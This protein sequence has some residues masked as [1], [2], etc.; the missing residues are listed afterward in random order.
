M[1]NDC[2][3]FTM[4]FFQLI[5]QSARHIY[6]SALP[7][8]PESSIFSSMSLPG[9]FT[10][11]TTIGQGSTAKI[12]GACDDGTVRVYESVTG[13]LRLSLRPEF[14]VLEMTGVPDGSLLVCTYSG[15]PVITL[16]DIQTGR[17]ME[18][19]ILR[20]QA[21]HTTVSLE[22][23]YLACEGSETT[24][25]FWETA[26]RMQH[27]VPW[28]QFP[29]NTPCWLAPEDLI[30][31]VDQ[32]SI[33]IQNVILRGPP[34]HKFSIWG[35]VHR[36]VYPR[37]FDRLVIMCPNSYGGNS[38]T[39]PD[40]K[41]GMSSTLHPSGELLPFIAFSQ[42]TEQ[43]VCG[44]E[45]PGLETVDISPGCRTRFDF[46]AR[47]TSISTLS[48]GTVVVNVRGSGIQLLRLHQE[49]GPPDNLLLPRSLRHLSTRAES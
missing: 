48:N 29:G 25:D 43:L 42:T 27:P 16:W 14:P 40:V 45:A 18:T 6:H 7:L 20:T 3:R 12:A 22:G 26:S 35:S 19:F 10:C 17:L 21:K 41:T 46:P 31:I 37:A 28:E 4:H 32:G 11:I 44:R 34:I 49:N 13:V 38:F 1:A 36:A 23:R 2:L 30:M 15:L 24:V 8:S 5:Q 33:C 39:I 47:L 9:G